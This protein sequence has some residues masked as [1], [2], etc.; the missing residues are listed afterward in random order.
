MG[1]VGQLGLQAWIDGVG[2]RPHQQRIAVRRAGRDRLRSNDGP[3]ARL[4]L[5]DDGDAEI[6]RHLLRQRSRHHVGAAARRER[7]HDFDKA[8]GIGR[9]GL[10]AWKHR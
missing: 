6:L 8:L 4:V 10:A 9:E 2:E 7:D 3:R 5:D 1:V